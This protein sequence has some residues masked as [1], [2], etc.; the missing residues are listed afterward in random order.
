[1]RSPNFI[2]HLRLLWG[3]RL[4]IGFNRGASGDKRWLAVAAFLGSS[5]PSVFLAVGFFRLLH[6]PV[7][8]HSDVWPEFI[9]ALLSFVT[10]CV[11]AIWPVL[12]AGVDDHSEISR[13][14]A[15]PISGWRLM[16]ASTLASLAEPR[17][18]VFYGPLVGASIAYL[19]L[20]PPGSVLIPLLCFASYVMFNAALSRIGLHLVLN[21]LRQQRSAE[22]IGGGFVL[23]LFVCSFIPPVD[24][25]WLT[26]IGGN[27]QA[28]PDS[29]IRDAANALSIF[30]TGWYAG[31]LRA[32]KSGE[33]VHAVKNLVDLGCMTLIILVIAYGLLIDFHRKSGRGGPGATPAERQAN[34]FKRTGSEFSTLVMREALDLWHN[35]RA[36]LLASV[37]FVLS[38]LLKLLSA[39]ALFYFLFGKT[40]DTWV[41]GGL[42]M[43]TAV[44]MASTFSQNAFAYDGHGFTVFL[45]APLPLGDVLKAK[46]LVHA[47]AAAGLAIICSLFYVVYFRRGSALDVAVALG[48]VAGLI[49]VLLTVGNFLSLFFPVKF[50]ANLKR[51]DKLPFAASM[52]GVAA[53]GLGS[54]P[55]GWAIRQC[56]KD[57]P[58]PATLATVVAFAV[59]AW[60]VYWV[61]RPSALKLLVE[62]RE[63]ILRAVTR[64]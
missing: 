12:S 32:L 39:R 1:M 55:W 23:F 36:R 11:W 29:I 20:H 8:A 2:E 4:Q 50:H 47:G 37:P 31:A 45:S 30:P 38:V 64:D 44:V 17:A 57:G 25:S 22:L 6:V 58:T 56:G 53:A 16:I 41:M 33:E 51:R 63:L 34:P 42:A 21:V 46:N 14:S 9:L 54:S 15:F 52:M 27:V 61:L 10:S 48:G 26:A 5:A 19:L 60:S 62:R 43:Y 28:V 13:Y 59:I 49:P 24:A 7:V 3:L 35:P 18:L 40:T